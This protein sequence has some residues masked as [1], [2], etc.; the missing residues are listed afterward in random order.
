[1][2]LKLKELLQPFLGFYIQSNKKIPAIVKSY[3]INSQV[4]GLEVVV[5]DGNSVTRN[6]SP[7]CSSS[8]YTTV[9]YLTQ[10]EGGAYTI[11]DAVETLKSF[12]WSVEVRWLK[13]GKQANKRKAVITISSN[14]ECS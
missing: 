6:Y 14:C 12:S 2:Y 10:H 3:A 11:D 7:S 13:V 9:I 8:L 4:T 5:D 1:M